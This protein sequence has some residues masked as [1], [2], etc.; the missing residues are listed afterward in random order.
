[1][2]KI[3]YIFALLFC[4]SLSQA[5]DKDDDKASPSYDTEILRKVSVLDIEGTTY[6]NVIITFKSNKPDY[7]SAEKSMV[8][9]RI[10]DNEGKVIYKK[11]FK[12]VFLYIFKDGQI[13]VAQQHFVK[14][15]IQRTSLFS[16]TFKGKIREKEGVYF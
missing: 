11:K 3:L 8:S 5:A 6:D 1:M 14:V 10:T 9:V 2:K 7:G 13:Q 12:H 15:L 4:F 16:D